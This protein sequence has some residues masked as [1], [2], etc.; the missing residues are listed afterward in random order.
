MITFYI[1][2]IANDGTGDALRN[3]AAGVNTNFTYTQNELNI[4]ADLVSGKIP[5]SQLPLKIVSLTT[6]TGVPADGDEWIVYTL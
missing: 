6:P 2:A 4:K 5:S 3:F 1:G